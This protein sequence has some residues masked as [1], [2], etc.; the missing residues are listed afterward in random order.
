MEVSEQETHDVRKALLRWYDSQ[1]RDLPWRSSPSLYKTVVSEF[2]LQ[3]TQ[4]ATVLPYFDR[5]LAQFPDFETLAAADEEFVLKHWEGLGY[6][7]RARFLHATAK[8]WCEAETK[9]S[10]HKDWLE[11]PGVGPYMAA[12]ISSITFNEPVPVV[13]G[14]VIRLITRVLRIKDEFTSVPQAIQKVRP[15]VTAVISQ[16]RPGDFNQAMME[17]GATV[18]RPKNPTC[19]ICPLQVLCRSSNA[20]DVESIPLI[21]KAKSISVLRPRLLSIKDESILLA[22]KG[23]GSRLKGIYE[24]PEL[25]KNE[26]ESKPVG[27]IK[28]GIGNEKVTEPI[29]LLD[30]Q[31]LHEI[32]HKKAETKWIP[33]KNLSEIT[34]SG[35]HRKWISD[36]LASTGGSC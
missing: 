18:C 5:W 21:K 16:E 22:V 17:M 3:Q 20:V 28:R 2:M 14:N 31:K 36:F 4:V 6:Y 30:N 19:M 34:L 32:V 27:T 9:P 25:S 11:Y 7:R 8:R 29:Y 26:P 10:D 12:A 24:L 1:K 35:P 33:L 23:E 15:Y 13:D